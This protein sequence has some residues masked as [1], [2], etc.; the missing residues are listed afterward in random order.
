MYDSFEVGMFLITMGLLLAA[1]FLMLGIC[2]GIEYERIAKKH[3]EQNTKCECN[4]NNVCSNRDCN[5]NNS[6]MGDIHGKINS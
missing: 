4:N 3:S 2:I 6:S 1:I 5:N